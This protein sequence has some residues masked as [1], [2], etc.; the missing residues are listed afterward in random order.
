VKQIATDTVQLEG[1]EKAAYT[2]FHD[3]LDSG[4]NIPDAVAAT[5]T[6][7]AGQD[8]DP[9]FWSYLSR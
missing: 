2:F 1:L 5:W 8:I 7:F 4:A 6:N 3:Q 9:A